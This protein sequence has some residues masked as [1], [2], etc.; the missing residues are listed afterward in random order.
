VTPF[1]FG[2]GDRRLFG[3]YHA[4]AGAGVRAVVC[5]Y[6]LGPEYLR[7][8]RSFSFLARSL[9][10]DGC[11]VLR[12]DYFGTGDSA[13]DAEELT[14]GSMMSDVAVAVEELK[15]MTDISTATL[16]G[17]RLGATLAL[18]TARMRNDVNAVVLWDPVIDG[19]AYVEDMLT[20]TMPERYRSVQRPDEGEVVEVLGFPLTRRM[21]DDIAGVG[22]EFG[23]TDRH[24][25]LVVSNVADGG[26]E[27]P[28]LP[29]AP[30]VEG[31]VRVEQYEGTLAWK[32]EGDFGTTGMPV[33]AVK[34]IAE[35]LGQRGG[36]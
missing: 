22:V 21:R 33:D 18:Q 9:A 34:R 2:T 12:F 25:T 26:V 36:W 1:Y 32:A 7:A 17:M 5:C 35:C 6:P 15:A 16:V 28:G 29:N 3:I 10:R 11:H 8:H 20:G 30:R 31:D 4:P 19:A 14:V 13:G 24:R 27:T 23:D